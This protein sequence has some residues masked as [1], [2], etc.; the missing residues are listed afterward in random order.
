MVV[1][2]IL[3]KKEPVVVVVDAV[4]PIIDDADFV[5]VDRK[6]FETG[7]VIVGFTEE[8]LFI[9]IKINILNFYYTT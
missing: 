7:F 6:T 9:I 4:E 5:E 3:L 1:Q 8:E 2:L